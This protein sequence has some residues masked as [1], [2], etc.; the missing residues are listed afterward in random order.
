[1]DDDK[2]KHIQSFDNNFTSAL[3]PQTDD[4]FCVF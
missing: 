1:M 2:Q 3:Q 4:F